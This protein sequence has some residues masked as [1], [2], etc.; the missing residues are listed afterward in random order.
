[1]AP[2]NK[3]PLVDLAIEQPARVTDKNPEKCAGD[4]L[5]ELEEWYFAE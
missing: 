5:R 3:Q 2:E 1:M 4:Q